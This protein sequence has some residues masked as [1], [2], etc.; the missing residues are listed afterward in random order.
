MTFDLCSTCQADLAHFE[1]ICDESMFDLKG[2]LP[3]E[4]LFLCSLTKHFKVDALIESG[5]ARGVSTA[6]ISSFFQNGSTHV[7]SVENT[8]FSEDSVI[9]T[10]RLAPYRN[11]TLVYGDA[12]V[13]LPLLA[14]KYASSVVFID[15][16]KGAK[17]V[18]LAAT[19]LRQNPSI[20]AVFIHDTYK[21]SVER[22]LLDRFFPGHTSSD[23]EQFVARFKHLD[24][25]CWNKLAALGESSVAPY[26]QDGQPVASYGHTLSMIL[27]NENITEQE[28]AIYQHL[29]KTVG[30]YEYSKAEGLARE[31]KGY[32]PR[33]SYFQKLL[34][35]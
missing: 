31:L 29:G 14:Q 23:D 5:R 11:L 28:S 6:L 32:L 12:F 15:G 17:A 9:A 16:P 13:R 24:T 22:S 21:G 18:L 25:P 19:L 26:L 27:N 10:R 33:A 30:C 2:V 35:G 4:M 20:H 7:C 34:Q 1:K 3:S 8:R